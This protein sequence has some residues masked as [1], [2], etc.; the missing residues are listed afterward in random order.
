MIYS[1]R[2]I[3]SNLD[4]EE[5]LQTE[6]LGFIALAISSSMYVTLRTVLKGYMSISFRMLGLDDFL[7]N[8]ILYI[9]TDVVEEMLMPSL[10]RGEWI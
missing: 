5:T 1:L 8:S 9:R 2:L 6:I 3:F 10:V 7:G 4:E